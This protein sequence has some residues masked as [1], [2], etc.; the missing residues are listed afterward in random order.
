MKHYWPRI[1]FVDCD[2]PYPK[3]C[4]IH[5]FGFQMVGLVTWRWR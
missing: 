3:D 1:T 4:A 2:A 5:L